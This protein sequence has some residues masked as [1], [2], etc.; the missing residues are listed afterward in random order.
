ME[1]EAFAASYRQKVDAAFA[2]ALRLSCTPDC[3]P[4]SPAQTWEG[5]V[6]AKGV[7]VG[8][9][10]EEEEEEEEGLFK[11]DAVEDEEKRT[12]RKRRRRRRRKRSKRS[13]VY[14]TLTQSRRKKGV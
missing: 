13:M 8:E 11:A 9:E 7:V 3:I 4:K 5:R 14:S 12:R 2:Q 10:E 1:Q 6:A